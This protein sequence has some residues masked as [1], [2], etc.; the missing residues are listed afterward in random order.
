[1]LGPAAGRQGTGCCQPL[2][3]HQSSRE[4]MKNDRGKAPPS[5][6]L[7]LMDGAEGGG[8]RDCRTR[9]GGADEDQSQLVIIVNSDHSWSPC[10]APGTGLLS[11]GP[12]AP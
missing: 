7:L 12:A 3:R 1:M 9:E 10:C 2:V 8:G 5:L 4:T 11:F 6:E